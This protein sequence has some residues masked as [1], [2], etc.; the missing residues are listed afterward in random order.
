[1]HSHGRALNGLLPRA[2]DDVEAYHVREGELISG[3]VNGW[4]FG[5]GH[6]HN[7]QLLEAVQERCGFAPGEVRVV[8]LESQPAHIQRQRYRIYDAADGPGR[9]G[10]GERRRHGRARCRGS[11]SSWDF[12][13]EV[14]GGRAAPADAASRERRGRRRL[15]ARTGSPAPSRWPARASSVTVLE[16]ADD[17]RR[18][19]AHAAS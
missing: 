18:R 1:M 6:F 8:T 12:P 11:T 5:D 4:N 17:D 13:V 7:H 16:A 14:I 9:G 10:L 2:V 19:H 3:V 15:R